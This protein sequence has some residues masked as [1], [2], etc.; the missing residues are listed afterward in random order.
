MSELHEQESDF[1][2][3]LR[4]MPL[5]D[6]P[7]DEHRDTLREQVLAAYDKAERTHTVLRRWKHTL[8][9][10]RELMRRP[11]PRLIAVSAA[12]L[13][14]AV[15]WLLAPGHQS[16][17]QAFNR[18]AKAIVAAKTARFQM[19]VAIEG[20]P[21]Q[22]F[23][24]YYLAPGRFRQELPGVINVSDFSAGKMVSWMPAEK[25]AMVMNLKGVPKKGAANDNYF[26]R[27]RELLSSDR[28]AKEVP[29]RFSRQRSDLVGRSDDGPAGTHRE[30]LE[31]PAK[32]RSGHDR[33]RGQCRPQRIPVRYDSAGRLQSSV[34]RCRRFRAYRA[35]FG[36]G[37]PVLQRDFGG[38]IS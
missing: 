18:F 31:R 4:Q 25:K 21:K 38:G 9:Y 7:S 34:V 15:V 35:R 14:V 11:I 3:L 10:G 36:P 30:R 28:D 16:T 17:A 1:S 8:N 5:A 22:K 33:L 20:Q 6:V 12:C 23:Q 27:L 37:L 24:A 13:F 29:F 2:R 19:E 26:E 32:N